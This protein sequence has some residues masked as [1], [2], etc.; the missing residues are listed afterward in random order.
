VEGICS[1]LVSK[2]DDDELDLGLGVSLEEGIVFDVTFLEEL[3]PVTEVATLLGS[4][5]SGDAS[6]CGIDSSVDAI[7][8]ESVGSSGTMCKVEGACGRESKNVVSC[9]VF[10]WKSLERESATSLFLPGICSGWIVAW[11]W[12]R[13]V[14]KCRAS[15][16]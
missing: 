4:G 15:L 10:R 7:Q 11:C 16:S 3:D 6:F 1:L 12:K 13:V 9:S 14:A 8:E 5:L 2:G